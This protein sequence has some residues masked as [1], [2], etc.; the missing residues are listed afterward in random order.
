M[1]TSTMNKISVH[2]IS[3]R[4]PVILGSELFGLEPKK[5]D[6][7]SDQFLRPGPV[8][9]WPQTTTEVRDDFMRCL[10]DDYF[11]GPGAIG[12]FIQTPFRGN[13]I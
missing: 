3:L 9:D 2:P 6:G 11:V 1:Q 7:L 12:S 13:L 4:I 5:Y 8:K 10:F